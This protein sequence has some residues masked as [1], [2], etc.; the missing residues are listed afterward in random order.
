MSKALSIAGITWLG[1]MTGLVITV[2]SAVLLAAAFGSE[3][4]GGSNGKP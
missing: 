3:K 2:V 4:T 1:L